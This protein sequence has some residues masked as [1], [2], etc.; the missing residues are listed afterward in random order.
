MIKLHESYKKRSIRFLE[1]WQLDRWRFKVYGI[2]YG[3]EYPKLD[4]IQQAKNLAQ[5]QIQLLTTET[6][7][8]NVGFIIVHEAREANFFLVDWWTGENMLVNHAYTSTLNDPEILQYVTP[9]GLMA[10]VW[11]LRIL[12]FERQAWI[13]NV[14]ANPKGPD[15]DTYTKCKL[16]DYV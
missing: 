4:L 9:T 7:V 14:L 16:D 13:D 10:C 15:L 8:Y 5:E 6:D 12:C 2:K 3:G 11:E 1:L